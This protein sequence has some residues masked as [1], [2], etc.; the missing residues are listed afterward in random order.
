MPKY[1]ETCHDANKYNKMCHTLLSCWDPHLIAEIPSNSRSIPYHSPNSILTIP[2]DSDIMLT[3]PPNSNQPPRPPV[4]YHCSLRTLNDL[5]EPQSH[6]C[7]HH[8]VLVS[9]HSN[10]IFTSL[11]QSSS[12]HFQYI[13]PFQYSCTLVIACALP[14]YI[15]ASLLLNS[16]NPL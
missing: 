15:C 6:F 8:S 10:P 11:S 5:W 14:S 1:P 2:W 4:H 3:M 7:L 12:F 16:C 13:A 9:L